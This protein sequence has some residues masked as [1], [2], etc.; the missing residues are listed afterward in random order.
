MFKRTGLILFFLV[1]ICSSF[2]WASEAKEVVQVAAPFSVNF[3][4]A[5]IIGVT[6]GLGFAAAACGLA[7]G[8]AIS[9]AVEGVSRQPESASK[10]N[11]M[12]ILGLAFIESLVIY[13]LFICIILLFANPFAKYFLQ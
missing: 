8:I 2:V 5:T 9:K 6:V 12:L 11:G 10:I 7:Q 1:M 13:V 4:M 3:F